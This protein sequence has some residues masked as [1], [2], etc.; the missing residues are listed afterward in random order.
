MKQNQAVN[1]SHATQGAAED[2]KRIDNE[3][4]RGH[5]FDLSSDF[6]MLKQLFRE[7][8]GIAIEN[9]NENEIASLSSSL[10]L[11]SLKWRKHPTSKNRS[12]TKPVRGKGDYGQED[13]DRKVKDR[14]R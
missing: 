3:T 13:K 2:K 4:I 5:L 8:D 10:F 1:S 11:L 14:R 6:K 12:K 7:Q 9:E